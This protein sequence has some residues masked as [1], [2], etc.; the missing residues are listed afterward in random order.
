MKIKQSLLLYIFIV[1]LLSAGFCVYAFW[2]E[3]LYLFPAEI[4]LA[5]SFII[6]YVLIKRLTTPIESLQ[7]GIDLIESK[8]FSITFIETKQQ[9]LNRLIKLYNSMVIHLREER[10]ELEEK[11]LFLGKLIKSSPSGILIFDLDGA[12]LSANPAALQLL[13]LE[14]KQITGR[15]L[16]QLKIQFA[17]ELHVLTEQEPRIVTLSNQRKIRIRKSHFLNKGFLQSFIVM[18]ELT[19]EFR[20]AE[21][22][23][24]EKLIR[25]MSHEVN[26]TVG[27]VNSLLSS[28]LQMKSVIPPDMIPDFTTALETAINRNQRLNLF[29][30]GFA[31]VIK[32]PKPVM[33]QYDVIRL[34]DG[35]S[36]LYHRQLSDRNIQLNWTSRP[37]YCIHTFDY[38]QLEQVFINLFKNAI[39]A[40]GSGGTIS[41]A[42]SMQPSFTLVS[43]TDSGCGIS[44]EQQ[45]Q[46]FVPFYTTKENGQGIGLTMIHDIISNHKMLISCDSK[47]NGPTTFTIRF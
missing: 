26:N 10:I 39:E 31:D 34:L 42:V 33:R 29:M 18:E 3:R 40:I 19:E 13:D 45:K 27:A 16:S 44:E 9:E 47:T 4:V 21:K 2:D 1:H 38:T 30:K 46:L 35:V 5:L 32:I 23:A 43:I 37:A 36:D 11:N 7:T 6:G 14:E 17:D 15:N 20:Q 12:V 41:L 25:M 28:S 24:Y 22:Q 8:D